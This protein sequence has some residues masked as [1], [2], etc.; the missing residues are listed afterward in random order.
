MPRRRRAARVGRDPRAARPA[1]HR[2]HR[3]DAPRVSRRHAGRR[4]LRAVGPGAIRDPRA[5]RPRRPHRPCRA[6][7]AIASA[8]RRSAAS[9]TRPTASPASASD[10]VF[11]AATAVLDRSDAR[12][13][14]ARPSMTDAVFAIEGDVGTARRPPRGVS[15]CGGRGTRDAWTRSPGS[16]ACATPASTACGCAI[17][18][19]SATIRS[20]GSRSCT[21]TSKQVI[22]DHL[23]RPGRAR[24][25]R[26]ARAAARAAVRRAAGPSC[27]AWR[28]RS[29]RH[30]TSRIDGPRGFRRGSALGAGGDGRAGLGPERRRA[31]VTPA[32][33]SRRRPA[34][35]AGDGASRSSTAPSGGP[36]PATAAP[37]PT[38]GP[39]SPR[40]SAGCGE[41]RRHVRECRAR[42]RTSARAAGGIRFGARPRRAPCSP[43]RRSRRSRSWRPRDACGASGIRRDAR[44][45]R[46][47]ICAHA[48]SSAAATAGRSSATSSP[49]SPC[50]SGR[51][52]RERW[53]KPPPRS[54][55]AGRASSSPTRKPAAGAARSC[56]RAA[57]AAFRRSGLQ[58]GFIYRHWLNY[59]HE[60]DEMTPTSSSPRIAAS[61]RRRARW[62][63]TTTRRV[64]S[65][66]RD[67]S[68]PTRSPSP[69]ARGSTRSRATSPD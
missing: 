20:G 39:C 29:P 1:R 66:S 64:T 38:S 45:G 37:R 15:R 40:S 31:R 54:T 61:R 43:S 9:A 35:S 33:A 24:G 2:R 44:S 19:P 23:S 57:G 4:R 69:A 18:S 59:L 48:R 6:A 27:R 58:H 53:T 50:C 63:S 30:A 36:M 17:A 49:A 28:R 14:R 51:G 47:P 65:P 62:S 16:R 46:A 26:R 56:S 5:G 3:P 12:R 11:A 7:R 22:V 10:A 67:A 52:R 8:G 25:A 41:E 32:L 55:P 13:A 34:R 42:R 21:C 60:P 68:L